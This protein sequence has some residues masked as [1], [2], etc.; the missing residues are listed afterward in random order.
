[1]THILIKKTGYEHKKT[2]V[3]PKYLKL[4]FDQYGLII[5]K[6]PTKYT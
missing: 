4:S 6:T 1:M 2:F 3:S 5:I